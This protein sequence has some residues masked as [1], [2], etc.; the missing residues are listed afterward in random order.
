MDLPRGEPFARTSTPDHALGRED[1]IHAG[2]DVDREQRPAQAGLLEERATGVCP[3]RRL[4]DGRWFAACSV[5]R[6]IAAIGVSLQDAGI[7]SEL[8]LRMGLS[9]VACVVI[10]DGRQVGA[11]KGAVVANGC[12][13][14]A[15]YGLASRLPS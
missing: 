13:D 1:R 15:R 8:S 3:A 7:P 11:A 12:L 6:V 5:E 9:T 10:A 14:P 2:D 4:Q